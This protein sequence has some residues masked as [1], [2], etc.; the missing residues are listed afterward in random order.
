MA[1]KYG[2]G[3]I[4]GRFQIIHKGHVQL[5]EEGLA[6]CQEFAI[7]VGSSQEERTAK[8]PF[9]YEERKE[10]LNRLFPEAKVYPLPDIGVGNCTKWGDY[11]IAQIEEQCGKKPDVFFSGEEQRRNSWL[12]PSWGIKE[13]FVP[14]TLDISS[15]QMKALIL[16]NNRLKWAEFVANGLENDFDKIK[17]ILEETREVTGTESL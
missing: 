15:T 11:V 17:A 4:V 3:V 2:L 10:F 14:K 9:S 1:K 13:V 6:S 8:N 12:D 5:I 7:F 16:A